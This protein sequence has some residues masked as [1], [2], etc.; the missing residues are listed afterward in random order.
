[1]SEQTLPAYI[2]AL[3]LGVDYVDIDIGMTKD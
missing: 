2:A 3:R 1:M